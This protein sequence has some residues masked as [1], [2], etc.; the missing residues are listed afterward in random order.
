MPDQKTPL[1]RVTPVAGRVVNMPVTKERVPADGM[2]VE[3]S[4]FWLRREA[5]GDVTI[6]DAIFEPA[7]AETASTIE[8]ETAATAASKPKPA[9]KD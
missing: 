6:G 4:S 2:N 7:D 8:T 9:K 5:D 3:R 1:I